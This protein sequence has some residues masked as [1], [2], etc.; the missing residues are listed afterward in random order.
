MENL[1]KTWKFRNGYDPGLE[2]LYSHVLNNYFVLK[3]KTLK[4]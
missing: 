4:I 2:M 1:E 3:R